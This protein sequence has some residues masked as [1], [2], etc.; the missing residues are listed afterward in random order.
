[1][2][3]SQGIHAKQE[4]L[5]TVCLHCIYAELLIQDWSPRREGRTLSLS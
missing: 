4:G 5:I 3:T 1:M 2:V